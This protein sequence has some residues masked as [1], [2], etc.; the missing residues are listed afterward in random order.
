M[1]IDRRLALNFDWFI[2]CLCMTIVF[3]GIITLYSSTLPERE[4]TGTP[5]YIKQI[6][7]IAIGI[8]A[9]ILCFSID[10]QS[11]ER[12][13]YPLFIIS[14][15]LLLLIIPFGKNI[16]GSKRWIHLAGI[17]FQSSEFFKITMIL[18]LSKYFKK[19]NIE[20]LGTI[21][22]LIVPMLLV[23]LPVS[24][25]LNQPDLGTTFIILLIF[26][27]ILLFNKIGR[28]RLLAMLS[29]SLLA[30]PFLCYYLKDYQKKRIL[31]FLNPELDPLGSGYHIIQSKIAIGSGGLCGKG[32][33]KG[34]QNQLLF[35]PEQHTDFI[36]S[37]FAEEWGFLGSLIIVTLYLTLILWS[38]RIAIY[39]KDNFGTLVSF[40][41]ASL[42]FWH[43]FINIGMSIGI[44]PVVGAPLPFMSY[45]GSSTVTFF[46]CIGLLINISMRRFSF[47]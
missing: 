34:T 21:Q 1:K 7:W 25:I 23:T 41:I 22:G 46:I 20:Y 47:N 15:I 17:S 37:V 16:S 13:A 30:V 43:V 4:I 12:F 2:L 38:F 36:F 29:I 28:L 3:I 40:G 14:I 19:Y 9:M 18:T 39:S 45:G 26:T 31:T 24:L 32:F 6:Y 5:I 44:M 27:S 10:Y 35:L 33:L 42:F 11:F 8:F